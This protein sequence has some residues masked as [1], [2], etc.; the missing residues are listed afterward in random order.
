MPLSTTTNDTPLP[1]SN[2]ELPQGTLAE[3]AS[4]VLHIRDRV[5]S[6]SIVN[7]SKAVRDPYIREHTSYMLRSTLLLIVEGL[8]AATYLQENE[9]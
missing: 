3:D 5:I 9:D 6:N 7:F 1:E 8:T 4:F 2:T